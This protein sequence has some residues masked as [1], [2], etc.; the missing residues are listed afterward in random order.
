MY[1]LA[2]FVLQNFKRILRTDPELSACAIFGYK[3]SICPE[4]FFG[5]KPLLLLSSTCWTFSLCKIYKNSYSQSK[6]VR[7]PHFWTQNGPFAPLPPKFFG[8]LLI[9]FLSKDQSLSLCKISKKSSQWIQSYEDVQFLG[10][11]WPIFRKPL[12]ETCSFNSCLSA[13]QKSKRDIN[14][15]VKY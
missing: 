2:P 12:N 11:K 4:Q 8:K 5:Y 14:L 9:S 3:R 7:M 13:S 15:L 6:V 10:V 1:L